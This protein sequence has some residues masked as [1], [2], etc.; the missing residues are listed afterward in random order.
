MKLS[1]CVGKRV[2]VQTRNT[3]YEFDVFA[4]DDIHGEAFAAGREPRYLVGRTSDVKIFGTKII[5]WPWDH[6]QGTDKREGEIVEGGFL[7]FSYPGY[8]DKPV[9]TS[10][11]QSVSISPL[12][13][14]IFREPDNP[15]SYSGS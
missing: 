6:L 4:L 11:I 15:T 7:R 3:R 14:E 13:S 8:E 9:N 12:A 1:D 10:R 5:D 2:V